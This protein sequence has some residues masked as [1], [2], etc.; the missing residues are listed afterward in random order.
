MATFLCRNRNL[1]TILNNSLY[2][3]NRNNPLSNNDFVR[4]TT[5]DTWFNI[6]HY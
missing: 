3:S 1:E 4:E 5:H 2:D 6:K